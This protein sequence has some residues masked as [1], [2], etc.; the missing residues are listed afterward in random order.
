MIVATRWRDV[1]GHDRIVGPDGRLWTVM[2]RHSAS[3]VFLLAD[4]GEVLQSG[5]NPDGF[6]PVVVP[7]IPPPSFGDVIVLLHRELGAVPIAS[8]GLPR[9]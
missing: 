5:V 3:A 2:P 6:A 8:E 4:S 1:V 7:D 9:P